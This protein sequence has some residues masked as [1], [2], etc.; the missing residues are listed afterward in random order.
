[1]RSLC[2][3]EDIMQTKTGGE[4]GE[5]VGRMG[6]K[7]NKNSIITIAYSLNGA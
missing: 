6:R 3:S 5:W 7:N 4:I 1:M 2:C